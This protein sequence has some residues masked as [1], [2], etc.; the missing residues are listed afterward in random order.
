MALGAGA[1]AGP[2]AVAA[3]AIAGHSDNGSDIDSVTPA[4]RI[5]VSTPPT[6]EGTSESTLSVDTSNKTRLQQRCRRLP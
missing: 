6:G 1:A 4:T 5:S 2:G 3:G